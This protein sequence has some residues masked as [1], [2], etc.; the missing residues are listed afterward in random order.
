MGKRFIGPDGQ[1]PIM[2]GGFPMEVRVEV[3]GDGDL[4]ELVTS[5][6]TALLARR[7]PVVWD[8]KL[9]PHASFNHPAEWRAVV[10]I[11][12]GTTPEALHRVV[13]REMLE[14]NASVP[15]HFRTRWASQVT[16]D[17]QEVYEERWKPLST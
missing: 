12:E 2:P 14:E 8:V 5:R 13:A 4:V 10:P 15:L 9:P 7:W 17:H 3:Y 16:P 1:S 6:I 11:P